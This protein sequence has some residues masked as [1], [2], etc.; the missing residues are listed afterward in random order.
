MKDKEEIDKRC[1]KGWKLRGLTIEVEM[2]LEK[3]E[4]EITYLEYKM[5][6]DKF[7]KVEC[8]EDT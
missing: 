6:A 5:S 4:S 8:K 7:I 3:I 2:S 1:E